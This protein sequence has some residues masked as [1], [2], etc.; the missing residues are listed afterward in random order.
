MQFF[1]LKASLSSLCFQ[2]TGNVPFLNVLCPN[3][4]R[5]KFL[6]SPRF[7][8]TSV[9][10]QIS[11]HLW[12]PGAQEHSEYQFSLF[13]LQVKTKLP[14]VQLQSMRHI[15][16]GVIFLVPIFGCSQY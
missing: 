13:G 16:I 5:L 10:S 14:E 9:K 7:E 3:Y 15:S 4:C 1:F 11:S 8:T 12:Y 6:S 2:K